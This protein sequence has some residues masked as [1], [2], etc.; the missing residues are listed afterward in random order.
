MRA[1]SYS[2]R[3]DSKGKRFDERSVEEQDSLNLRV[4]QHNHWDL[5]PSR[6]YRD[7]DLS[8]SRHSTKERPDWQRLAKDLEAGLI[9]I[10]IMYESS[11][12]W[13]KL[14]DWVLLVDACRD[15][16]VLMH[17]TSHQRTYD[18]TQ[19]RDRKTLIEE[20]VDSEDETE[21]TSERVKRAMEA[22]RRQ[23]RPHSRPAYGYAIEVD[24]ANHREKV[25]VPVPEQAVI[26]REIITR[27]AKSEPI[28]VIV[29]DLNLRGV[30][31]PSVAQ[32]L[33]PHPRSKGKAL[34]S[35]AM[36]RKICTNEAY[37]GK[38]GLVDATWSA[39]VDKELFWKANNLLK[40]PGRKTTIPARGKHV[41]SFLGTCGECSEY[42]RRKGGQGP[43]RYTCSSDKGCVT[44]R[45][46]W[47]DLFIDELVCNRLAK[48]DVFEQLTARNDK[49]L[50]AELEALRADH[51]EALDLRSKGK[52]SLMALSN[53][54]ERILP[55][56]AE[57][58]QSLEPV[59]PPQAVE[60]LIRDARGDLKVIRARWS[61][62]EVPAKKDVI[63][64]LFASI[65]IM[66]TSVPGQTKTEEQI[67]NM[68]RSRVKVAWVNEQ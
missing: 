62:L 37:I 21:K 10:L 52:L 29:K 13:R 49:P 51:Q 17:I 55:R 61:K 28:S 31:S 19:R 38:R 56:I 20:G 46:D 42:L 5:P 63:R 18:L 1:S 14:S 25:R 6:M 66:K 9:D 4:A 64:T 35:P 54:E 41:L 40:D 47:V 23:G 22:N 32:G 7:N 39:I 15:N 68:L 12:A 26:V 58:E 65:R 11:R 45:M 53:E 48:G 57:L 24:P 67:E 59:A 50:Y 27:V 34:W 2:R 44:I 8:A 3:S 33:K 60:D 36:I 43:D 16:N 30:D